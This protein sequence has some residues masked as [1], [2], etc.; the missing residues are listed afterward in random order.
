M[1]GCVAS[2]WFLDLLVH[3][4]DLQLV[5]GLETRVGF[6]LWNVPGVAIALEVLLFVGGL[7]LYVRSTEAR[8]AGGRWGLV[9]FVALLVLI[10]VAN[11]FGPPPTSVSALAPAALVLWLLVPWA[12]AFDRR[13]EPRP[14]HP[15]V[16]ATPAS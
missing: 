9:A 14:G 8:S 10:E 13:R 15:P 3:R 12:A 5:P 6:G 7:L 4:P 16:E 1:G 11:L 2:H